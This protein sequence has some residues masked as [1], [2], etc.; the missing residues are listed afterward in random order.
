MNMKMRKITRSIVWLL[1]LA[2]LFVSCKEEQKQMPPTQVSVV[3][4]I[5]KDVPLKHDFIGQT[6]GIFDIPIRARVQGFLEGIH[7][8]EGSRVKKGDHL[9]TIDEQ[10]YKAQLAAR[11]SEVA[12]AKTGLV[13]AENDL[14][15]YKPLAEANAV[16]KSDLDNAVAQYEAA[17]AQVAAAQANY[18][19]A[20]IELGYCKIYSPI[21]GFIGKTNAKVGEFV[22]QSPNPVILN[23]VSDVSSVNVEFFLPEAQYLALARELIAIRTN[24]GNDGKNGNKRQLELILSDGSVFDHKGEFVFIDRE[25][26]PSTGSLLV[27]SR[28]PNP[29]SLI[30]PGQYGRVRVHIDDL[31]NALLVPQ[32]CVTE[33]QGQFSVSVLTDSSSIQTVQIT[34]G[35][36]YNDLWVIK[37]GL[38]PNDKVVLDGIQ[39]VRNGMKVMAKEVEYTSKVEQDQKL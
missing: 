7:F 36:K 15:R 5:Q 29:N 38:Q 11:L 2:M 8:Q 1:A 32:A 39:K 13:K 18:E 24:Q 16:S 17:K 26:N 33:L 12:E 27:Q 9:Y 22:G 31:E 35:P 20:E 14:N 25:V 10:P 23:T 4:V 34:P 21:N 30:R 6:Y 3:N 37:D 28:F 19:L